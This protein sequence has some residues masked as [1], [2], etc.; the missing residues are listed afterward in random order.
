[1]KK[2]KLLFSVMAI[3]FATSSVAQQNVTPSKWKFSEMSLGSAE[4]LF[5]VEGASGK[6]NL[7]YPFRLADNM[8]GAIVMASGAVSGP[9]DYNQ[10]TDEQKKIFSDFYNAC[11]IIDGGSLGHLFCYQG[12][13]STASDSRVTKAANSFGG[14]QMHFFSKKEGMSVGIYRVTIDI[15]MI[16]NAGEDI[17][18]AEGK[19]GISVYAANSWYDP[20]KYAGAD[21]QFDAAGQNSNMKFYADFNN[22][23]QTYQFEVNIVN[24]EDHDTF[25]IV[26]KLGF[27]KWLDRSILLMRNLK[28]EKV[29]SPT[30]GGEAKLYG[31]YNLDWND[32]PTGMNLL[33]NNEVIVYT[34]DNSI[35]VLDAK[36]PIEVYT[37]TGKLVDKVEPTSTF[38]SIPVLQKGAYIV[39]VGKVV[40][41]VVF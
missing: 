41:K 5:L 24:I 22:V 1:M 37:I 35:S 4:S 2:E 38:T 33:Y 30:L 16:L 36:S 32:T 23:W 31:K 40:K 34:V 7:K 17:T 12:N 8:D 10:F 26:F 21:I 14:A 18:D 28:I 11:Q 39:K 15:R 25:P 6:G 19:G 9:N 3:L 27:G 29:D 20:M 13:A